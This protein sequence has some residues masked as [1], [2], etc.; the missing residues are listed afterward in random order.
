MAEEHVAIVNAMNIVENR[1][2]TSKE[3]LVAGLEAHNLGI[4]SEADYIWARYVYNNTFKVFV[5]QYMHIFVNFYVYGYL[6]VSVLF[7]RSVVQTRSF[8][9]NLDSTLSP[10]STASA[11]VPIADMANHRNPSGVLTTNFITYIPSSVCHFGFVWY[12]FLTLK[13]L[14]AFNHTS[15]RFVI[16]AQQPFAPQDPVHVSYGTRRSNIDWFFLYGFVNQE[17]NADVHDLFCYC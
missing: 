5:C 16:T 15:R 1:D 10:W 11:L 6:F 17:P 3:Q 12:L 4:F 8:Q 2:K 14:C 9:I 13:T 7:F